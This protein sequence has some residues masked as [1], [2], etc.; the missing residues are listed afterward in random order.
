MALAR[1]TPDPEWL[2]E[3]EAAF[4]GDPENEA[5]ALGIARI[6]K[7]WPGGEKEAAQHVRRT[8]RHLAIGIRIESLAR[9]AQQAK[10]AAE[11]RGKAHEIEELRS[12]LAHDR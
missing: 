7:L 5:A 11:A 8:M 10:T 12:L 9:Q 2:A 1:L 3:F 6:R 4:P